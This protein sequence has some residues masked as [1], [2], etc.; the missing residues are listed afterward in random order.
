MTAT[1]RTR[2]VAGPGGTDPAPPRPAGR[3]GGMWAITRVEG[4]RLLRDRT[5]LFFIVVLPVVIIIIIGATIGA[6]P[7]NVPIGL[8]DQDHTAASARL[9]A[10][11]S[12]GDV[13]A[14]KTYDD[15]DALRTDIRIQ[16]VAG[17]VVIPAGYGAAIDRGDTAPV[18]LLADQNQSAT[19]T[20][21]TVVDNIVDRVGQTQ[22]AAVFATRQAGGDL[23]SSLAA[24][25][26]RASTLPTVAVQVDSV[27]K[28]SLSA[29]N[30]YAYTAPSNLVLFVF[31]NALT[32]G[33]A[34]VESRR[35]GITRRSLAAPITPGTIV[36]GFGFTR[37]LVALLQ[38]ALIL[39]VGAVLFGVR[40]GNPL[41]AGA[42]VLVFALLATGAGL[43]V[44][45][46][47]NTPEQVQSIGIPVAIG[48]AMLGG[49]M[50]PLEIVPPAVRAAG[51]LT[52]H[53]WAM[54][55]W[56]KLI[57]DGEGVGAIAVDLAVLGAVAAVLLGLAT[58]RLRAVLDS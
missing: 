53:A 46:L 54:D 41:G 38:S 21:R 4:L 57:F 7:S 34:M 15:A 33:G 55:A 6:A 31:V 47:A 29:S 35:Y 1:D 8:I 18:Q 17:G 52:P 58:W 19:L 16:N 32:A 26:A 28:Q 20:V 22:A 40:W 48:M 10:A 30:R 12:D 37:L 42:L 24:A 27:G 56:I 43:L 5:A 36:L 51:H 2:G 25:T 45:T 39:G 3:A 9:I 14:A 50:W 44:G 11:L 13:I 49:C 23:A